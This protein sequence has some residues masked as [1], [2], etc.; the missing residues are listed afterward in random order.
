MGQT[1]GQKRKHAH[2]STLKISLY[3]NNNKRENEENSKNKRNNKKRK[4]GYNMAE[5]GNAVVIIIIIIII[6]SC[7]LSFI[8]F[9]L[10]FKT[11]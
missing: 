11:G 10:P 6:D 5:I 8:S 2:H 9:L 7:A 3:E 1:G 4:H